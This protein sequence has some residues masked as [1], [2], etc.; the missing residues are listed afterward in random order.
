[1]NTSHTTIVLFGATGDLVSRKVLPALYELEMKHSPVADMLI[2]FTRRDI[3]TKEFLNQYVR[4]ALEK[5]FGTLNEDTYKHFSDRFCYVQGDY[6]KRESFDRLAKKL[7][8]S[9]AYFP[10]NELFYI[11]V[12]PEHLKDIVL[13]MKESGVVEE[14]RNDARGWERVV[15]EKPFGENKASAEELFSSLRTIFAEDEIYCLDHYLGKS[16]LRN[17]RSIVKESPQLQEIS[18]SFNMQSIHVRILESMGV[19]DRGAFYDR[20]GAFLDVGQNHALEMFAR[21]LSALR[22]VSREESLRGLKKLDMDDIGSRT[23]RAQYD[24]YEGIRNVRDGSDTETY[25]RIESGIKNSKNRDIQVVLEGGK[26]LG[27]INQKEIEVSFGEG[28]VP[29]HRLYF[30]FDPKEVVEVETLEDG[31]VKTVDTVLVC[32][33]SET[34]QYTEEY[35][36]LFSSVV[37]SVRDDSAFLSPH[38]VLLL[39]RFA[40]P[41][42][43]GWRKGLSPLRKYSKNTLPQVH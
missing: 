26:G 23:V 19:E 20:V 1:M 35:K 8:E 34:K 7:R 30:K 41:I 2:P 18:K 12:H 27:I 38:E 22:E 15:V 11:P 37:K 17:I 28:E 4:P 29:K 10:K 40:D 36:Y 39:W 13:F 24:G 42:L 25:F 9:K 31:V 43:E 21:T 16:I 32:E 6:A 5:V 14:P 3:T 33:Q